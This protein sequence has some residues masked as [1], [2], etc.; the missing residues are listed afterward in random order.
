[1]H[2]GRYDQL[3]RSY[4]RIL[5]YADQQK[6]KITLPTREVYLKGPGA[7]SAKAIQRIT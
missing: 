6:T 2:Q 5:E 1:M 3:G 4:A 7:F